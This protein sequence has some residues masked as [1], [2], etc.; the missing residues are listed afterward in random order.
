M[1]CARW[2]ARGGARRRARRAPRRRTSRAPWGGGCAGGEA[3]A[4]GA[5]RGEGRASGSARGVSSPSTRF[6]SDR[7]PE[8][9]PRSATSRSSTVP[10]PR[11]FRYFSEFSE[12][13]RY[14][15]SH[16]RLAPF[17]ILAGAVLFRASWRKYRK[18]A[19]NELT[20]KDAKRTPGRKKPEGGPTKQNDCRADASRDARLEGG[21]GT[22]TSGDP[23]ARAP[24]ASPRWTPRRPS[25]V[26]SSRMSPVRQDR[27]RTRQI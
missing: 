23:R 10:I 4:G 26:G 6:A 27:R 1:A 15:G 24:H 16:S 7:A 8:V 19:N 13:K 11:T 9:Y 5:L 25:C 22:R 14:S 12:P 21:A 18:S 20:R 2:R 3:G 17:R